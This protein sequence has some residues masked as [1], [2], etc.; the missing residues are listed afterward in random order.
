MGKEF[1]ACVSQGNP[2]CQA[3]SPMYSYMWSQKELHKCAEN[4]NRLH[5]FRFCT[6]KQPVHLFSFAHSLLS[7][8]TAE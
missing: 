4:F 3:L 6:H 7:N 2:H 5:A 1:T 8:R